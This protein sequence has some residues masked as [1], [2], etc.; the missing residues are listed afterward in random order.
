MVK[1]VPFLAC[2]VKAFD[3]LIKS[4]SA[5]QATHELPA[6]GP[7]DKPAAWGC[8]VVTTIIGITLWSVFVAVHRREIYFRWITIYSV[9]YWV[10][11]SALAL[12]LVGQVLTINDWRRRHVSLSLSILLIVA[13]FLSNSLTCSK[14]KRR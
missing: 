7:I 10:I 11:P 8:L 6:G 2:P 9:P 12:S 1:A 5:S 14:V 3:Q 13:V 4:N